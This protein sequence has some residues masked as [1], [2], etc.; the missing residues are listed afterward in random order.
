MSLPFAWVLVNTVGYAGAVFGADGTAFTGL[1]AA[2]GVGAIFGAVS[3]P[4]LLARTT[5][6]RVILTGAI[7][8]GLLPLSLPLASLYPAGL[9][10]WLLLGLA[11]SLVL[12]PGG[13]LLKRS[14]TQADRPAIF[15]AQFTLSHAGWLIAYPLAGWLG[16]AGGLIPAF[17]AL[18][19]AGVALT[20]I[21][22][23]I[24]PA[25]VAHTHDDLP[26]D[27]PHLQG[28]GAHRHPMV[29]DDLHPN[30]MSAPLAKPDHEP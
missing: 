16:S 15:A 1:M 2:Y 17:V 3:V 8:M 14:A 18:G 25:S 27:H 26:A 13:L 30:W 19:L 6:R 24:W 28:D 7:A 21:A 29:V 23:R 4:F 11:A 9:A 12:T 10:L 5:E 22:W 20:G